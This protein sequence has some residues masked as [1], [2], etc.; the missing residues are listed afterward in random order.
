MLAGTF[1]QVLKVKQVTNGAVFALK[2]IRNRRAF[3]RQAQTEVELLERLRL[4]AE[5]D[6]EK[7][8][9]KDQAAGVVGRKAFDARALVVQLYDH[10][11][12]QSHLCLLFEPLG[13]N[14]LQLLQQ[15]KCIGLSTSLIRYF[16]KQLL[17][18]LT[19]LSDMGICHCDLKPEN[20]LLQNLQSPAIKLIDFGSACYARQTVHS[21]IQSR[22]YRSP[23]VL[24]GLPYGCPIDIWSMGTIVAELFLGLPLFPGESEYNQIAR[25][26]AT[27]GLPPDAMVEAKTLKPEV[28][29]VSDRSTS[30]SAKRV[31]GL[32]TP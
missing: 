6:A 23:E 26:I 29:K 5:T 25:I 4:P 15:N 2:V 31:S 14:L 22:F 18:V 8:K 13:V 32:S 9:E 11:V 28:L 1:G 24:L 20:I 21:Y 16:C 12:F 3:R 10:F 7:V 17:Q 27:R 19:L 30:S